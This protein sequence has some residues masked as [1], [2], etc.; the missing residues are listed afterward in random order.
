MKSKWLLVLALFMIVSAPAIGTKID[1]AIIEELGNNNAVSVIV[2]LE[3]AG[4]STSSGVAV[5]GQELPLK[6]VSPDA[7]AVEDIKEK[8]LSLQRR[9]IH[10]LQAQEK[11]ASSE[12]GFSERTPAQTG[13][14]PASVSEAIKVEYTYSLIPAFSGIITEEGLD[15]LQNNRLVKEVYLDEVRTI[16]L[17][18]SVPLIDANDVWNFT[19]SRYNITGEGESICIIDTGVDYN[20][21]G[22]GGGLGIRVTS[23]Y[24][25]VNSDT[26]PMDD[27]GHGTHVAGIAASNDSTYKGVAPGAKIIAIKSCNSA[28]TCTDSNLLSGIDWCIDNSTIYNISTISMSL[29]GGQYTG[30]CDGS[31]NSQYSS[32]INTALNKNI[33]VVIATGNTDGTYTNA[34]AGVAA[35]ACIENATRIT[36]TSKSDA[37]ASYAFRHYNFSNIIAAPGSSITS[38]N[39]G[40]GTTV[41][42]GTSM[43]TPHVAGAIALIRQYWRLA[44]AATP[45]TTEVRTK[46]T[47]TGL[48]LQD[49]GETG[50][51]ITRIKVLAAVQPLVNFTETSIAN[52]SIS[53]SSSALV[54]VSS[55]VNL[56]YALL[57]WRYN[58]GTRANLS[59]TKLN[60]TSFY[61]TVASLRDG[62]DTYLVYGNDTAG[63]L[64]TSTLRTLS[65]DTTAPN[66]TILA[67]AN[68]TNMS[69]GTK[70]FNV[71]VL[72]VNPDSVLF[73]FTNATGTAFNVTP[74]NASGNWN[75]NLNLSRLTEGLQ[76]MA[77]LANDS[78]G[79]YNRT[80]LVQFTVDRTPP[81]VT[82]IGPLSSR[83]FSL[84]AGNKT[85]NLTITDAIL[86]VDTALFSFDNASGTSFNVT[87][88]NQSGNWVAKYNVSSLAEGAHTATAYAND[89]VGNT[90]MTSIISFTVDF[91][92]PS[93]TILSPTPQQNYTYLSGNQT[94]SIRVRDDLLDVNSV[95]LSFDNATGTSFNLTAVNFSGNW[96]VSYN[97]SFLAQGNHTV[98][99]FANDSVGNLNATQTVNFSVDLTTPSVTLNAPASGSSTLNRTTTFNCS[100]SDNAQ[101]QNATLYGNWSSGWHA[102]QTKGVNGTVNQSLFIKELLDGTYT[103]NCQ[104]FDL[105]GLSAFAVANFTLTI[106][107]TAPNVSEVSSGTP[108][109]SSATITWKTTESANSTVKY[110]TSL[111]FGSA[112][113]GTSRV[114]SHSL[115]L[116][117]LSSSTTYYFNVTYCDTNGNC[118]T[119]GS[120]NFTTG[121]SGGSSSSS[122]SSSGGGGGGGGGGSGT[123]AAASTTP[124]AEE[125]QA[126]AATEPEAEAVGSGGTTDQGA[127]VTAGVP[128]SFQQ[129]V[130][131]V[132]G[133]EQVVKITD[134]GIPF[135]ELEIKSDIDKETVVEVLSYMRRPEN[136]PELLN[137]YQFM[138]IK[139]NL[140]D[141][142]VKRVRI[143]FK[144][145]VSWLTQNNYYQQTVA[146]QVL[147]DSAW[148]KV[149]AKLVAKTE[150][151]LTYQAKVGQFGYFAITAESE[152]EQ[153][154]FKAWIPPRFGTRS[155]VFFG[156]I[157]GIVVLIAIYFMV[158]ERSD[159]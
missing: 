78:V 65:I 141:D 85:F 60:G 120:Y 106:D 129:T 133:E 52:N 58:N 77:V 33:S 109:S 11:T 36:A 1:P 107:G 100:L 41:L 21:A 22:L 51:K 57:E 135:T 103:W 30:Y 28:G 27:H 145:P 128:V 104:V 88:E 13:T 96:S 62:V 59:M 151:D 87:T 153:S 136:L 32:L 67:P 90:N 115:S 17:T 130:M 110:G 72:D 134:A 68:G 102:N 29:G 26:D 142:E 64:G 48:L 113:S 37:L 20:H 148:E 132:E 4:E 111:S 69:S 92:P 117:G 118:K 147:K 101:L 15:K 155:F 53:S 154:W 45:S 82:V 74:T 71:T 116:S 125:A 93:V 14:T 7:H 3:D 39:D 23:G 150:Q 18:D 55:D 89:T 138:E 2:V 114:V 35:P 124:A 94:F 75:H 47:R 40:G 38:L 73:S 76:T 34:T 66:V 44:Y 157:I 43:A 119:T 54:N 8:H 80:A 56:S 9:V 86:T 25:F 152:L 123:V 97:V 49:G 139:A 158:R 31:I 70:A 79:N 81:T 98:T 24:D 63:T 127:A 83:N 99:V 105:D 84:N 140:T 122:S 108:T 159:E 6:E 42:S 149:D 131:F 16:F 91:T 61:I 146:L 50:L 156:L 112:S 19:V 126:E 143:T 10:E 12:T 95:L 144:I 5:N 46:L 137:A 121:A